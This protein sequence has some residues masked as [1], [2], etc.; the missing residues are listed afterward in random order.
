MRICGTWG[1]AAALLLAACSGGESVQQA[2][3]EVTAFHRKVEAGAFDEI[4]EK[5]SPDFRAATGKEDLAQL[6]QV[7]HDKLGKAKKSEQTGWKTNVTTEGSFVEVQM[8]TEFEKGTGQESFIFR[9]EDDGLHLQGY[10][11]ESN[12]LVTN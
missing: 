8:K 3:G 5:A 1:I 2:E 11:I 7:V 12:A 6:L 9:S 4:W 10:N